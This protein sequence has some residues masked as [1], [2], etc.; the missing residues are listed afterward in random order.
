M[1]R[2]KNPF[3]LGLTNAVMP[4]L[5]LIGLLPGAQA[6]QVAEP[7]RY[8]HVSDPPPFFARGEESGATQDLFGSTECPSLLFRDGFDP[9]HLDGTFPGSFEFWSEIAVGEIRYTTAAG[10]IVR[11][12]N[13]RVSVHDPW[14]ANKVEHGGDPHENLN[15]KHIKDWGGMD[16]WDGTRRTIPIDGGAKVTMEST[17]AQGVTLFTS[18][19]DRSQ[20]VQIDNTTGTVLHHSTDATDTAAREAAQYDGETARFTVEPATGIAL[21]D[22]IYN[23][24][25]SFTIVPF[26]VPLGKTGGCANPHQVNDDFDDPSLPHT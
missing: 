6:E 7:G 2:S 26:A 22:N 10:L 20:N 17:G 19:Y 16:G 24:D 25:S 5:F 23:E 13:H 8:M 15:G 1:K 12:N 4:A 21:Y 9:G 11:V 3:A 18:I 14:E